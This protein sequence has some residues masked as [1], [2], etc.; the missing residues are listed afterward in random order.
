MSGGDARVGF[1]SF[2]VSI[3]CMEVDSR[4]LFFS[5]A[6]AFSPPV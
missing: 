2:R 5:R 6:A 3:G 1:E 4:T